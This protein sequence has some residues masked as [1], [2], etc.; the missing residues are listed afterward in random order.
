MTLLLFSSLLY[1]SVYVAFSMNQNNTVMHE[2]GPKIRGFNSA[3]FTYFFVGDG[4]K[5]YRMCNDIVKCKAFRTTQAAF[6]FHG[7]S[8]TSL[9]RNLLEKHIFIQTM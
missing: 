1:L 7:T 8:P 3:L 2:L 6:Q 5:M 9:G 4:K